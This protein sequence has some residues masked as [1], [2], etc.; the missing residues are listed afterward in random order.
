MNLASGVILVV[1]PSLNVVALV[2]RVRPHLFIDNPLH[3]YRSVG[4]TID[5]AC[6]SGNRLLAERAAIFLRDI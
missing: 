3:R 5:S 6:Y 1:S 4:R 2:S